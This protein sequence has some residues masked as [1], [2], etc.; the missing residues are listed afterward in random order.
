MEEARKEDVM[1]AYVMNGEPLTPE[2]GY[3][4]RAVVPDK[5]GM[6]WPKWIDEIE[7]LDYDYKGYWEN[8]GWSDYAG[9]D[10]PNERF[11]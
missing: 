9:R 2:Q 7:F 8:R 6:K 5:Y 11:E 10:R 1:L 3:P 4:L